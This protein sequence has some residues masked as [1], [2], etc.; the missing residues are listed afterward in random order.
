MTQIPILNGIFT[1]E[2]SDFRNS[3]PRNLIPVAK[4][5]GIS[6][7]Y[8]R[9]AD[10]IVEFA[11]G[12]PGIDRGGINWDGICYRVMGTKFVSV[13]PLG[14]I[15]V[16]GDVG[17]GGQVTLDYSFDFL[18][19]ASNNNLF[20]YDKATL[21]Q[22]VDVNLGDVVDF[23]W[24]DGYFLTTDGEF[25]VVTELNDPFTVNPLKFGSSEIDP[26]PVVGL[27]ELK[28]EVYAL[29]RFTI[30]VFNNVGGTLFPF[31]RIESAAIR[32]GCVGTH[33]KAIFLEQVAFMGGAR[34]EAISIWLGIGGQSQRIATREI[35]QILSEFTE[36][37]LANT[38]MEV[39]VEK[40]HQLLY[41]HLPDRTI[42]YE[43]STSATLGQ[44]VW[45]TLSSSLVGD[46]IYKAQNLVRVYNQWIVGDPTQARLGT[47]V[48]NIS[49]H[50]GE[51][52][53]WD[54]ST[55]I[56]YNDGF[57]AVFHRLELVC[58][59]GRSAFGDESTIWMKYS[60]DGV[61]FSQEFP[62]P[63]GKQGDRNN[64]LAW[65]QAGMMNNWR[66]QSFRGTSD[67][68]LSIARLEATMEA[69]NV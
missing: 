38:L 4:Q 9:P 13:D 48:D 1:D 21:Q 49:S 68:H 35:D 24:I 3:Y 20:L 5:Q 39:R 66:I 51:I 43:G 64:R 11:S 61:T 22:V 18:G 12:A 27:L 46:T 2:N 40:G 50:Y 37:E 23:V 53:G 62:L 44:S 47:L 34:N 25:L 29:N 63:V 65:L 14:V 56:I 41:I 17:V 6:N 19:I 55:I 67:A 45:F 52:I 10:G 59:T 32:R 15:T 28:N 60:L 69:L 31:E 57:G 58:L 42:V 16:I 7:G 8:L 30:E 36:L 33:A 54:F 26:D